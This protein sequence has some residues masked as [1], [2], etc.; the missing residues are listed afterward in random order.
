MKTN[1][2]GKQQPTHPQTNLLNGLK[3]KTYLIA[4]KVKNNQIKGM[5]LRIIKKKNTA[6]QK[7]KTRTINTH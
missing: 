1:I 2:T 5:I 7:L 6:N 3:I 4:V